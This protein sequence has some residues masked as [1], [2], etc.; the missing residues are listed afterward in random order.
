MVD[1]TQLIVAGPPKKGLGVPQSES[2]A[3][4]FFWRQFVSW[5]GGY[6]GSK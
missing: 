2:P 5:S 6:A 1:K 4:F 3:A